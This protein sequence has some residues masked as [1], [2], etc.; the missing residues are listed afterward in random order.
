MAKKPFKFGPL[1]KK[2]LKDLESGK[3]KQASAILADNTSTTSKPKWAFCCLGV[4]AVGALK[5]KPETIEGGEL[6]TYSWSRALG[7]R[8][9]AGAPKAMDMPS[10]TDMNDERGMTF[11]Q[12]AKQLRENAHEYFT[13]PR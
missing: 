1:Q 2:W 7:L 4:A 13:G 10:C 5:Q 3:F 11:E 6:L 9:N 8:D 12:I